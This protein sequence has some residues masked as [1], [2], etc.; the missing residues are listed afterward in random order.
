M[1]TTLYKWVLPMIAFCVYI[2]INIPEWFF[3]FHFLSTTEKVCLIC[4]AF[5]DSSFQIKI[6]NLRVLHIS[7]FYFSTKSIL[8]NGFHT[9][10][11]ICRRQQ[12]RISFVFIIHCQIHFILASSYIEYIRFHLIWL[13][14]FEQKKIRLFS[15]NHHC[16]PFENSRIEKSTEKNIANC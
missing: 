3:F 6:S 2:F 15:S 5:D 1:H 14:H 7:F 10:N 11:C 12:K 16:I 13:L 9:Y 8:W 4:I